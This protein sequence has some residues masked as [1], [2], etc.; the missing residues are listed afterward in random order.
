MRTPADVLHSLLAADPTRPRL[1][2]YD[3]EPG[4]SLGE[5]IELSG[6]VLANWVAKAAN[7]LQDDAA[8]APGTT[9]GLDL[10]THWRTA[11]WALAGWEV[12]A[13]VVVGADAVGADLLV[14]DSAERAAAHGGDAVL[15]TLPALARSHPDAA[16]AGAAVDEAREL[17]TYGDRFCALSAAEPA[18]VALSAGGVDTAYGALVRPRPD[19]GPAP[20]VVVATDPATA[21]VQ[22]LSAWAADGSVL[23]MRGSRAGVEH[24]LESEG[25]TL[26]LR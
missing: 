6:R 12:G 25:V 13:T 18:E 10:P 14:T 19:W 8:A 23:M 20:R 5:R 7:L 17:A 11:Y 22:A 15:V 16:E 3:D 24:R 9:V 2:W 21:L 4:P 1:T 26:D